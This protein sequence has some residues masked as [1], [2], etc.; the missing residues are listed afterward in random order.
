MDSSGNLFIADTDNNRVRKVDALTGNIT[1]IAGNG[2][3]GYSGD[4][5]PA[6]TARLRSPQDIAVDGSGNVFIADWSNNRIR[7]VDA[8]TGIITTVAGNGHTGYEGDGFPLPPR[9]SIIRR[10]S[11]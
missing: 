11:L 2:E 1:T 6:T 8:T 9:A 3:S 10:A 5:G 4:N 7:R